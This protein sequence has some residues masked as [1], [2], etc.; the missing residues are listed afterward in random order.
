[1]SDVKILVRASGNFIKQFCEH[2][3]KGL[4]LRSGR[5]RRV[6]DMSIH[7]IFVQF[8]QIYTPSRTSVLRFIQTCV[9]A[10]LTWKHLEFARICT[11]QHR[12][13]ARGERP[14]TRRGS[15][16]SNVPRGKRNRLPTCRDQRR[17]RERTLSAVEEQ[18]ATGGTLCAGDSNF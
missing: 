10:R 3:R 7:E 15:R 12:L 11:T 18:F 16:L 17:K 13:Y 5:N 9:S 6:P 4:A 1:M 2:P 14:G 8:R